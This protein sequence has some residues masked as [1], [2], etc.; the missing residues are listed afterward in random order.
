VIDDLGDNSEFTSART[1]IDED[2]TT[3]LDES[4]EGGGSLNLRPRERENTRVDAQSVSG[5]WC[6]EG[7]GC[8]SRSG[9][10]ADR[11]FVDS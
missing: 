9:N 3:D 6:L 2:D 11:G 1:V 10:M 4:L 7:V 8:G 5:C